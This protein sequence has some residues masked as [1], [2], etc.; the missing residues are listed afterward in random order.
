M[1][2]GPIH[3]SESRPS[4]GHLRY[5]WL[6]VTTHIHNWLII[7]EQTW[8]H[9]VARSICLTT[10]LTFSPKIENWRPFESFQ[11]LRTFHNFVQKTQRPLD[12]RISFWPGGCRQ[13]SS[14]GLILSF[15][16]FDLMFAA[17]LFGGKTVSFYLHLMEMFLPSTAVSLTNFQSGKR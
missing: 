16:L 9:R 6:S 15:P 1:D 10:H 12:S 11:N 7:T 2:W 17:T 13:H 8:N 4:S 14:C 3:A 5:L